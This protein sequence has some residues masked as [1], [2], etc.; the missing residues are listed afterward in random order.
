MNRGS[1]TIRIK[2]SIIELVDKEAE[3][4]NRKTANMVET[5][6]LEYFK[7]KNDQNINII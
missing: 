4:Q 5:I 6:L 2:M 1:K 3:K 7:A